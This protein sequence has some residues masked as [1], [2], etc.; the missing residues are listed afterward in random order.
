[1]IPTNN[2]VARECF[3]KLHAICADNE[4]LPPLHILPNKPSTLFKNF[5]YPYSPSA[6]D[7]ERVSIKTWYNDNRRGKKVRTQRC[8]SSV[9][10]HGY[11][12]VL[13]GLADLIYALKM[14]NHPTIARPIGVTMD[15]LQVVLQRESDENLVVEYLKRRP[16]A[17]RIGLVSPL[18]FTPFNR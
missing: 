18:L 12:R 7:G 4:V 13:Q 14:P 15:F 8:V 3:K 17:D 5:T 10:A 6:H 16:E 2:D 1:M 11:P 9:S